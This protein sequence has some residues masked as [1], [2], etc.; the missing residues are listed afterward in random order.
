MPTLSRLALSPRFIGLLAYSDRRCC[1]GSRALLYKG[2][3]V[4]S[5]I[6][7]AELESCKKSRIHA[8]IVVRYMLPEWLRV[9]SNA[10]CRAVG[11][12]SLRNSSSRT[13]SGLSHIPAWTGDT[14]ITVLLGA[15]S[16]W[17]LWRIDNAPTGPASGRPPPLV[18][19][20]A[21]DHVCGPFQDPATALGD[22]LHPP[23]CGHEG[24]SGSGRKR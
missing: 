9:G 10:R 16:Q 2:P 20:P 18:R 5:E 1:Q 7:E 17:N 15:T 19:S 23:E 8:R 11:R 14:W 4:E 6:A 22:A 3:D 12:T 13:S 24:T 21:D